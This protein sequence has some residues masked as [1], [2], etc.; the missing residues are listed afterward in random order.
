MKT[1]AFVLLAACGGGMADDTVTSDGGGTGSGSSD[2]GG[3]S[4]LYPLAMGNSWTY[5]VAAVG[6]GSICA[7]GTH[8]QHI[9]SSNSVGTRPAFQMTNF[10]SGVSATYD[11]AAGANDEIDFYY[12]G[13]WLTLVDPT[14]SEGHMWPY[15]N[16]SYHWHRE[17][18]VTVPA[19]TYSDCWTAVQDVSY[20]ASLTYCRG[21]GLVRSYSSDLNG[22]GWDAKL[23]AFNF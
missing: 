23:A 7:A 14:L 11:Y 21:V 15:F 4:A 3:S 10:C 8:E 9:V 16:T 5:A 2:T 13:S 20:T 18:S 19:G 17:T 6:A 22:S 1:L 12:S